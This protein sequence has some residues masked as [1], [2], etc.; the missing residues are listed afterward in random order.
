MIPG[1]SQTVFLFRRS[2]M[3]LLHFGRVGRDA[4]LSFR[5]CTLRPGYKGG[6]T[7]LTRQKSLFMN[8]CSRIDRNALSV[9]IRNVG[10]LLNVGHLAGV[11]YD[12]PEDGPDGTYHLHV[13]LCLIRVDD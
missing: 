12:V 3:A 4:Y 5:I 6:T 2:T 8:Q 9:A 1:I 7:R 10:Q 13:S 11:T